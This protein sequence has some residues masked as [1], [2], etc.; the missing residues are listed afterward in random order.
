MQAAVIERTAVAVHGEVRR[1]V[2]HVE[3]LVDELRLLE[4]EL[5]LVDVERLLY[6][7]FQQL[8]LHGHQVAD[9]EK[10]HL[11]RLFEDVEGLGDLLRLK[12]HIRAVQQERIEIIHVQ[13]AQAVI[14]A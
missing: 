10:A 3:R 5:Q 9:A 4:R 13:A 11:A 2:V 1:L 8:D 14:H 12:Q 6:V 7:L